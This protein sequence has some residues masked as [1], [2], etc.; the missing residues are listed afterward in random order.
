MATKKTP[1]KSRS[2]NYRSAETGRYVKPTYGK[3]HPKTTVKEKR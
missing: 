3:T 2:G 1:P